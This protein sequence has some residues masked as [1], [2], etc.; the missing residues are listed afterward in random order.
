MNPLHIPATRRTF[1][2]HW[3]IFANLLSIG[4]GPRL[5]RDSLPLVLVRIHAEFH[6]KPP[7][8]HYSSVVLVSCLFSTEFG[9][10]RQRLGCDFRKALRTDKDCI[11]RLG[12]AG[13]LAIGFVHTLHGGIG[14]LLRCVLSE[15]WTRLNP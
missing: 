11:R 9:P 7:A 14:L 6:P 4:T 10:R 3:R 13:G 1:I 5:S 12:L 8:F 15:F 2:E